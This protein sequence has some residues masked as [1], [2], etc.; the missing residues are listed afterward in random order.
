MKEF[1]IDKI[2]IKLGENKKENWE[3]LKDVNPDFYWLHLNS[4]SSGYI[5]I[6]DTNPSDDILKEG[7][8]ICLSNT[9]YRNLK[10]IKICYT[11]CKNLIKGKNIGEVYFKSNRQVKDFIIT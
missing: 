8:K 6:E 9:K 2:I 7:A 5:I 3:L 1:D 4:F 10:N 11:R